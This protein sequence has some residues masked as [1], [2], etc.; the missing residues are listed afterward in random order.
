MLCMTTSSR[1]QQ[2]EL[3]SPL[4]GYM[5]AGRA[6]AVHVSAQGLSAA[7]LSLAGEGIVTVRLPTTAGRVEATLP[8]LV[9]GQP[10][11]QLRWSAGDRVDVPAPLGLRLLGSQDRLIVAAA[12]LPDAGQVAAELFPDKQR[13]EVRL[14]TDRPRLLW[15]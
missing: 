8:L 6:A 7:R 5:R 14:E 1:A 9:Q 10:P 12:G 15:P 4:D 2:V 13:I 3:S 11:K